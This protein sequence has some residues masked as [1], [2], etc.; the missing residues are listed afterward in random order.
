MGNFRIAAVDELVAAERFYGLTRRADTLEQLVDK[1]VEQGHSNAAEFITRSLG[2]VCLEIDD[3]STDPDYTMYL[4]NQ[5]S[6]FLQ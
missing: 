4:I 5:R 1:A 2:Q 3:A 6:T